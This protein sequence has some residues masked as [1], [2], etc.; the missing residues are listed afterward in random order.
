MLLFFVSCLHC[1]FPC[2]FLEYI[3]NSFLY[4]PCSHIS[5]INHFV[6]SIIAQHLC[7]HSL[8]TFS[9]LCLNTVYFLLPHCFL[10]YF[11][12][13]TVH[14]MVCAPSLCMRIHL[15]TLL[16]L[17]VI[18]IHYCSSYDSYNIYSSFPILFYH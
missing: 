4:Y 7:L 9:V 6:H 10:I 17:T 14:L 5:S 2:Y 15:F 11:L 12:H 13:F 3:F 18:I 8:L 1:N 16:L